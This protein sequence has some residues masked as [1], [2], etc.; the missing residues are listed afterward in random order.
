MPGALALVTLVLTLTLTL[1]L[2]PA[3]AAENDGGQ[4]KRFVTVDPATGLFRS[5][6]GLF[7]VPCVTYVQ[8]SPTLGG[9]N[10]GPI[11]ILAM[12]PTQ[13]RADFRQMRG[14]GIRAIYMRIGAGLFFNAQG[15]W[16]TLK[17]PFDGVINAAAVKAQVLERL[18]KAARQGI[19]P[20]TY[21]YE[22]FDYLLDCARAEGIYVL[23]MI[24]DP[25]D[26]PRHYDLRESYTSILFDDTWGRVM[27]EWSKIAGHLKD[28]KEI[29]G[30]LFDGEMVALPVWSEPVMNY[31]APGGPA[32][33]IYPSP[34]EARDP[35]LARAFQDFLARRYGTIENLKA[36]WRAGYDRKSPTYDPA[37]GVPSYPFKAGEF[38]ALTSFKEIPLPTVERSRLDPDVAAGR[39]AHC[40]YW[41]NVPFDPI[42]ADFGYFKE[43]FYTERMSE[44]ANRMR[45]ADP[46]HLFAHNAAGDFVSV[47][48]PFFV[49]WNHGELE[50]D[51]ILQGNGYSDAVTRRPIAFDPHEMV[52]EIYQTVAPYRPFR[53]GVGGGARAIGMGEGGLDLESND[54]SLKG[55]KISEAMQARWVTEILM[56]NFGG[57]SAFASLWDWGTLRG[58]SPDNPK[59]HDHQALG[60]IG[61][62]ALALQS[63][64]FTGGRKARVLI[65]ANGPVLHSLINPLE[66]NN[67]IVLSSVL[68]MTHIAFDVA[69]TDEVA[70]GARP[71]KVDLSRYDAIFMPELF[72]VPSRS[73]SP[74]RLAGGKK[75]EAAA[76]SVWAMLEGWLAARP[77]RV[78]CVGL[79]SP[80]DAWFGPLA[81]LPAEMRRVVG[82]LRPGTLRPATGSKNWSL[83]GGGRL[84]A[85][86]EA[87]RIQTIGVEKSKSGAVAPEPFLREGQ[88][89]LGVRRA[90]ANGSAVYSFGFPL[91]LSW[92][93]SL[94][95]EFTGGGV[96]QKLDLPQ[97]AGFYG[98]LIAGAGISAEYEADP[99]VL[100]YIG[101]RAQSVLIRQRFDKALLKSVSVKSPRLAGNIY[102]GATSTITCKGGAATGTVTCALGEDAAAMLQARGKVALEGDGTLTVEAGAGNTIILSGDAP[103]RVSFGSRVIRYEPGAGKKVIPLAEPVG[104]KKG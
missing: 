15:G 68:A 47:W 38:A 29:L 21:T 58:I 70:P 14:H 83:A 75:G 87:I 78:L 24:L 28:R 92:M 49:P 46:N 81:E 8:P 50:W 103:A 4:F 104:R 2:A 55:A 27:G 7:A 65:L 86:L 3:P 11:Q 16:R 35:R 71:G 79:S 80:R 34:L 32:I 25:W 95:P 45:Q 99:T 12:D 89:V 91:G 37:S 10:A 98:G 36:H 73:L 64:H 85:Q 97:W 56:D 9:T 40:P 6:K 63:D 76:P 41:A 13:F 69:S 26:L 93:G 62:L 1:A 22:V 67:L 30:Y 5:A 84:E 48:H 77:K 90:G 33:K 96:N 19:G 60:S 20:F 101:D 100:A 18:D 43:R 53:R 39:G 44:L 31:F 59:I 88:E 17:D 82:E 52:K 102:Y 94:V 42:W 74:V 57:G 66:Y 61:R 23:P 54:P 51:V 72:L